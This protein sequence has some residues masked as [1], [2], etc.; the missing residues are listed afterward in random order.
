MIIILNGPLGIGKSATSWKLIS[1]FDKAIMLDGDYIGA[2]HPFEIQDK[3]RTTYLYKTITHLI[4]F[5]QKNDYQNFVINYV[6]ETELELNQLI[7][8][9]APLD[10]SI[11]C[12]RLTCDAEAHKKRIKERNHKDIEYEIQR[13]LELA[14]IQNKNAM[15]GNLGKIVETT[16]LNPQEVAELI[17]ES[18]HTDF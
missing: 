13:G 17:Y 2:V 4:A 12:L 15:Q 11:H 8:F 14:D 7:Q 3:Y 10:D 16:F 18:V 9:L 1:L 5:H 6:F